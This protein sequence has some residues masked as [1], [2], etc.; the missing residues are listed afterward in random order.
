[1]THPQPSPIVD[2]VAVKADLDLV[3]DLRRLAAATRDCTVC[4]GDGI[5]ANGNQ[6]GGCGGTGKVPAW[7]GVEKTLAA[8]ADR[9]AALVSPPKAGEGEAVGFRWRM[10][11]SDHWSQPHAIELLPSTLND[12]RE[13]QYLYATQQPRVDG[14]REA[15]IIVRELC[16]DEING[17]FIRDLCFTVWSLC[18]N[19]THED[20]NTD[21]SNDTLPTVQK[22][23]AKVRAVLEAALASHAPA[24][25][26]TQ[27]G[28][29]TTDETRAAVI[30]E[31]ARV[32][33]EYGFQASCTSSRDP[34]VMM[35][36]ASA[37][38][39]ADAI[40]T[41]IRALANPGDGE[42]RPW[43]GGR[44]PVPDATLVDYRLRRDEPGKFGT[45]TADVLFWHHD[46]R[47]DDLI[48]WRP[49]ALSL[50]QGET[51]P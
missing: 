8:A 24:I 43:S 5:K 42:W 33:D 28:L 22:G 30:E 39:A 50:E 35:Q 34:D 20:G 16:G 18:H 45:N 27:P 14:V 13:I 21:W 10:S 15:D 47:G 41:A 38:D 25:G 2:E 1:M 51:A 31:C 6:C 46:G 19:P 12:G 26:E 3:A 9:I 49:A 29:S 36:S 44:Q 17:G 23:V 32:A 4:D 11:P 7:W 40:A 48:A 37:Q